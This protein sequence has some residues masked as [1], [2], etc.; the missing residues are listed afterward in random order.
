MHCVFL[1]WQNNKNIKLQIKASTF[2]DKIIK[3][4]CENFKFINPL[5]GLI[6]ISLKMLTP[7][8]EF[9]KV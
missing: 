6:Q 9:N 2:D 4:S 1:F 5:T 8:E 7:S 3:S